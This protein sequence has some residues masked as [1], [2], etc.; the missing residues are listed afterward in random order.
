MTSDGAQRWNGKTWFADGVGGG[1]SVHLSARGPADIWTTGASGGMNP[2]GGRHHFDGTRWSGDAYVEF[3]NCDGFCPIHFDGGVGAIWT[4]GAQD[5][6][7]DGRFHFDGNPSDTSAYPLPQN[8]R[9]KLVFAAP[10]LGM[11][12]QTTLRE[13]PAWRNQLPACCTIC[14]T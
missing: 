13:N 10:F 1:W 7:T 11:I 14:G 3:D 6:W 9:E 12:E 8:S 2:T 5:V 4:F